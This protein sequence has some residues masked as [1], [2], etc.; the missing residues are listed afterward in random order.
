MRFMNMINLTISEE[1]DPNL[2]DIYKFSRQH[3]HHLFV[4]KEL[5]IASQNV[6]NE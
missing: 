3:C 2:S 6:I 5:H 4:R 1:I